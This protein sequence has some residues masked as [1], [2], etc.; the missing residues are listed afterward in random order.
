MDQLLR[1]FKVLQN[2]AER[3][4][5]SNCRAMLS[6]SF[7]GCIENSLTFSETFCRAL[8]V[9]SFVV[10]KIVSLV[11]DFYKIDYTF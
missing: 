8:E 1:P 10:L 3:K 5:T 9:Y 2:G 6:L 7:V 4:R 11:L